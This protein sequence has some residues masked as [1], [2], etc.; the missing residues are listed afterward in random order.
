MADDDL[1]LRVR[2]ALTVPDVTEKKMFGGVCFMI[3]GHMA[4][5]ASKRG[6]LVRTGKAGYA[7][8]LKKPGARPMLRSGTP[9][10]GYIHVGPEGTANAR[11][12][13]GWIDVALAEVKTLPQKAPK[14]ASAR[15]AKA[16]RS[17][18]RDSG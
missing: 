11:S 7:A 5:A 17:A 3:D 14:A 8:A 18:R 2:S 9:V 15:A 6:L 10:D 1:T 12:L 13:K 16:G 4:L